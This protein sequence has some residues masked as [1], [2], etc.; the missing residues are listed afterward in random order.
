MSKATE[1]YERRAEWI[2]WVDSVRL[3]SSWAKVPDNYTVSTVDTV[4]F[5]VR[6]D[7]EAVVVAQ[8]VDPAN[9]MICGAMAIPKVAIVKRWT[10]G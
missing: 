5:V 2:R 3:D 4:G 10:I 7:D 9:D 6:E 8:S 1:G